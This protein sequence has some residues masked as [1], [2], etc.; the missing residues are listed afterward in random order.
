MIK[1]F[2]KKR[3]LLSAVIIILAGLGWHFYKA[4]KQAAVVTP[5]P[6]LVEVGKVKQGSIIIEAQAV[7]TL[8]AAKNVRL[9]PEVAGQVAEI[10]VNDGA[11]VKQG[12]PIIR[13]DDAVN[14]VKAEAAEA[15]YTYSQANYNRMQILGKKGAISQQAIEQA[16]ADFKGKKALAEESR[17]LAEKMIIVAPFDGVLGKVKVSPGEYVK[18]GDDIVSLTDTTNLRVEFSVSEKYL[19][20][21]KIGQQVTLKTSAYPGKEFYGKV[22]FIAPTINTEDRTIS[23][24][25]DVPNQD[26]KLT[27]GLFVNV[28]HLMGSENQAILIPAASLVATIDGQQVYKVVNGKAIATKIKLGQRTEV[29]AQVTEGLT[30]G[31]SVVTVGQHKLKDGVPIKTK[32]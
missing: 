9:A 4:H 22:A 2:F 28:T 20:Q 5:P 19:G 11:H 8:V 3:L 14:K 10:L 1:N 15:N 18:V 26:G 13:L 31:D 6:V 30:V 32:V 24:Y 7:G 29:D 25:A 12:M 16:S 27:S 17:F 21:L 23:I